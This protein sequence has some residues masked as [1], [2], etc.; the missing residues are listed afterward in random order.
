[1]LQIP[2]FSFNGPC[3]HDLR[4]CAALTVLGAKLDL[5]FVIIFP[6]EEKARSEATEDAGMAK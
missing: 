2:N 4:H 3:I 1:L 5:L 6:P